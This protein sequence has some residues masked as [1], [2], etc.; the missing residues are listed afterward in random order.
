MKRLLRYSIS[1]AFTLTPCAVSAEQ[2]L[3]TVETKVVEGVTYLQILAP[4]PRKVKVTSRDKP[5]R[6]VAELPTEGAE[7][8]VAAIPDSPHVKNIRVGKEKGTT[9]I[10]IDFKG[11]TLP[12][13]EHSSA[14]EK[15]FIVVGSE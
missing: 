12:R 1:A 5:P 13:H 4:G 15:T 6:L 2:A 9:K 7:T 11:T 8:A 3:I 14:G 10:V